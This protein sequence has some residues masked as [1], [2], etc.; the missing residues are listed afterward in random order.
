MRQ[1]Y[2]IRATVANM[3]YSP[4][5][6]DRNVIMV[7]M[8]YFCRQNVSQSSLEIVVN[9]S[10]PSEILALDIFPNMAFAHVDSVFVADP[11]IASVYAELI[12]YFTYTM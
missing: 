5:R 12:Q 3:S 7:A 1:S 11:L 2:D 10:H 6:C 9:C 8:P 4:I